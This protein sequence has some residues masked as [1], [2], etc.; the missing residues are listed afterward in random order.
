MEQIVQRGGKLVDDE[1]VNVLLKPLIM[2][3]A[4]AGCMR[5]KNYECLAVADTYAVPAIACWACL[6]VVFPE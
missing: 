6:G 4:Y 5:I 2:K 3:F 1:V